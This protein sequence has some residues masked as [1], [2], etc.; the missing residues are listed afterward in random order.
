MNISKRENPRPPEL[1]TAR[2]WELSQRIVVQIAQGMM[3]MMQ[4]G[5]QPNTKIGSFDFG[6][7]LEEKIKSL[8]LKRADGSILKYKEI[9]IHIVSISNNT[10]DLSGALRKVSRNSPF[11]LGGAFGIGDDDFIGMVIDLNGEYTIYEVINL[12]LMTEVLP[13]IYDT[14]IHEFTHL[15]DIDIYEKG[16]RYLSSKNSKDR[17]ES[18]YKAYFNDEKEIRAMMRQLIEEIK[19][20]RS[21]YKRK[22]DR[23]I[24]SFLYNESSRFRSMVAYLTPKN[25]KRVIKSAIEYIV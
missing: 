23:Q 14:L 11:I 12:N 2:I 22:Y 25:K 6:F 18:Y 20:K 7:V 19:D 17:N 5:Y 1:N 13:Q 10:K 3:V 8:D 16:A 24:E 4:G 15:V 9:P 21:I